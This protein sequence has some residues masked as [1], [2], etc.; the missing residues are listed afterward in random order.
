[1]M[2]AGKLRHRIQ[3]Q[4]RGDDTRDT[5]GGVVEMWTT[6][7]TVWGSVEPL[8]GRELFEAQQIQSRVTVRIR[9]R[10]YAGLTAAHRLCRITEDTD[11][12]V[13]VRGTY[14]IEAILDVESRGIEMEVLCTEAA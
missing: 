1:M 14:N 2:R 11:G 5:H 6:D 12:N 10:H 9:M 13:T 4:S 7:A 3:I 8:Q